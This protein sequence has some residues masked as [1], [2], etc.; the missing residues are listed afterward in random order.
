M[1]KRRNNLNRAFGR[2]MA[3]VA[4]ISVVLSGCKKEPPPPPP[5]VQV[6]PL[7]KKEVQGGMTSAKAAQKTPAGTPATQPAAA[8]VLAKPAAAPAAPPPSTVATAAAGPTAGK[9]DVQK[10]MSSARA[11]QSPTSISLD[12]TKRRD[13]FRPYVQAPVVPPPAAGKVARP[14]RDLLP[15]QSFDTESFK[16]TG[17]IAG[18]RDNSALVIDPKGK[19]YVVKEGMLLGSNNGRIKKITT[20]TV[21]VEENYRDDS[22]KVRKR[23]VKLALTRKR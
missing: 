1:K 16:V 12:F 8:S 6:N 2:G 7:P 19:G 4:L 22:G 13:P 14:A 17:I 9:A 18:L 23:V 10:Q 11:G 15:I 20:S 3:A 5:P 21:E